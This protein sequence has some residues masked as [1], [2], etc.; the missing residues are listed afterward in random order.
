MQTET[1]TKNVWCLRFLSSF[2]PHP[3]TVHIVPGLIRFKYGGGKQ[4]GSKCS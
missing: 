1:T 4:T 2:L 3:M